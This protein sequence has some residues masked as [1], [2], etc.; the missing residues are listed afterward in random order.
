LE[1]IGKDNLG[2]H[3]TTS[4]TPPELEKDNLKA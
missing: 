2:R 4:A 3:S 1:I